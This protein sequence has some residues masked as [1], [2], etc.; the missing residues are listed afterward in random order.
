M[1]WKIWG[2]CKGHKNVIFSKN[3]Q[4][5]SEAHTASY[6]MGPG[7]FL[8]GFDR[9]GKKLNTHLHTETWLRMSGGIPLLSL[10]VWLT[11][12]H[13]DNFTLQS[14]FATEKSEYQ[15]CHVNPIC[16]SIHTEQLKS[17][18]SVHPHRTQIPSVCPSTQNNSNP[19]RLSIHTEQLK[20]QPSV[21][22]HR[23][24]QIPSVCPSTQNNSNPTGWTSIKFQNIGFFKTKIC[25]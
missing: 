6:S 9:R 7:F 19:I 3:F 18:L 20:S 1:S 4:N 24:T 5:S 23:T 21:H 12:M 15:L 22:P 2:P 25:W 11:G 17:H 16:L 8:Q 10:P 14:T 13:W